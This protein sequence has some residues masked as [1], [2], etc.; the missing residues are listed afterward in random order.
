MYDFLRDAWG[1]AFG[2]T[3]GGCWCQSLPTFGRW[4]R[5]AAADCFWMGYG[6][7]CT[8]SAIANEAIADYAIANKVC[9]GVA[10]NV[11][12]PQIVPCNL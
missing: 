10:Q 12:V 7:R 3:F 5:A 8:Y 2:E 9:P 11:W 6:E 1:G 4:V